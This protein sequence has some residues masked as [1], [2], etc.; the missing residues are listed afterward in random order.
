MNPIPVLL[1]LSYLCSLITTAIRPTE[2]VIRYLVNTND[3][4]ESIANAHHIDY[5]SFIV[6]NPHI[7]C[8]NLY[9]LQYLEIIVE[10]DP[11]H[12][13]D[14]ITHHIKDNESCYSIARSY[15]IPWKDFTLKNGHI[16][17][18]NLPPGHSV[19]VISTPVKDQV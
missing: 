1:I 18:E 9:Y 8:E 13:Q 19:D 10:K 2:H 4:C 12:I 7:D 5:I 11:K 3:S 15:G 16:D 14:R 6:K 17:C